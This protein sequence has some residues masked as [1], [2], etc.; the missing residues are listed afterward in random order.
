MMRIIA[1]IIVIAL[2][3]GCSMLEREPRV[4]VQYQEVLVPV[5]NVP[6]PPN[7]DCPED[8]LAGITTSASDGELAKAYR[9]AILQLRDCSNLR[10]KIIAKYRQMAKEDGQRI[11]DIQPASMAGP[12]SMNG[13]MSM[14]SATTEDIVPMDDLEKA[15]A[16]FD[17]AVNEA[18]NT[19][20]QQ[21]R[22][23]YN[24]E[25]PVSAGGPVVSTSAAGTDTSDRGSFVFDEE[26]LRREMGLDSGPVSAAMPPAAIGQENDAFDGIGSEF[27]NLDEKSYELE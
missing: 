25:G 19:L 21:V 12:V 15:L 27:G 9:I 16:E 5:S 1:F 2:L 3:G 23:K 13:P 6:E 4:D 11:N 14:G 10:E 18:T 20:K 24:N 17:A 26:A 7:T 22:D 8:A